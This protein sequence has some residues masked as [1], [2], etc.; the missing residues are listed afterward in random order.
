MRG[1][2][3]KPTAIHRRHSVYAIVVV[4]GGTI[5]VESKSVNARL[6]SAQQLQQHVFVVRVFRRELSAR[7]HLRNA[8]DLCSILHGGDMLVV[9]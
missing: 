6:P 7:F 4:S 5:V 8:T 1:R 9:Q 2:V 3:N